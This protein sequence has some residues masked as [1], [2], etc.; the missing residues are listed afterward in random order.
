MP[1][2]QAGIKA[3]LLYSQLETW[4]PSRL[5]STRGTTVWPQAP[6]GRPAVTGIADM[7]LRKMSVA[8]NLAGRSTGPI[9]G[10]GS[11]AGGIQKDHTS[12][13]IAGDPHEGP[14]G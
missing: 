14:T 8:A 12:C 9:G 6:S 2:P 10:I 3:V 5:L 11:M 1:W 13:V 4:Q 7:R